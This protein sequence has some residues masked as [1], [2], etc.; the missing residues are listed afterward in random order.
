LWIAAYF[1]SKARD[2][3]YARGRADQAIIDHRARG[4]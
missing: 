3:S 1:A 4:R 2:E